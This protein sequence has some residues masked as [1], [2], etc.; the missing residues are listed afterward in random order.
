MLG[1]FLEPAY[2]MLGQCHPSEPPARHAKIFRKAVHQNDL[3]G[4]LRGSGWRL[5]VD[6]AL[7]DLVDDQHAA[8]FGD[9]LGDAPQ[10]GLRNHGA[11]GIGG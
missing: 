1:E 4:Q 10:L 9:E 5:P 3:A 8:A 11:A 2:G 6:Q 7:V